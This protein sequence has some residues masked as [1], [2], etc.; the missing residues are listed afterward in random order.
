MMNIQSYTPD[1]LFLLTQQHEPKQNNL[2]TSYKEAIHSQDSIKW[3]E[4]INTEYTALKNMNTFT[5]TTQ[6][7]KLKAQEGK[8]NNSHKT[9]T[10]T[11]D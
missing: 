4:A 8:I 11:Q 2:P 3:K 9:G 6:E 5:Q 10:K 7:Q 1:T